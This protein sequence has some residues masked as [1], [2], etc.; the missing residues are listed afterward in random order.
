MARIAVDVPD[1]L[2]PRF[3]ALLPPELNAEQA[4]LRLI[5]LAILNAEA[6]A[7]TTQVSQAADQQARARR[8]ELQQELGL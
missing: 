8:V 7:F 5:K 3:K 6:Q 1:E 2:V 4:I